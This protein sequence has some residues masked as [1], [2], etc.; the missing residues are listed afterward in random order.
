MRLSADW[1]A[2]EPTK[3]R[4]KKIEMAIVKVL[5]FLFVKE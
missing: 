5:I 1:A 4:R 2:A 3:V